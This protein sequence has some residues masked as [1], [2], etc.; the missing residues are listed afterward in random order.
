[1]KEPD[2]AK[3]A[4]A[5][6]EALKVDPLFKDFPE[7]FEAIAHRFW[8]SGKPRIPWVLSV[9]YETG[10]P[11]VKVSDKWARKTAQVVADTITKAFREMN[12]QIKNGTCSWRSWGA[13]NGKKN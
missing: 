3:V 12:E 11:M 4:A 8:E 6:I 10:Q 1:M 13:E 7:L 9:S 5:S 2:A